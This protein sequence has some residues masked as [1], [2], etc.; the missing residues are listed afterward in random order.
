MSLSCFPLNHDLVYIASSNA[1]SYIEIE[2]ILES[3]LDEL[4]YGTTGDLNGDNY[5]NILD[6]III[7]NII[8]GNLEPDLYQSMVGDLNQDG[9]IDIIDIITMVNIILNN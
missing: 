8:L 7:V 4:P 3:L 5:L 2:S 9:V 6:I 1:S